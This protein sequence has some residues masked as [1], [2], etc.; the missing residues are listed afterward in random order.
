MELRLTTVWSWYVN[1]VASTKDRHQNRQSCGRERKPTSPGIASGRLGFSQTFLLDLLNLGK[2]CLILWGLE[3]DILPVL[4]SNA[5]CDTSA[6]GLEHV[7]GGVD[8]RWAHSTMPSKVV[9]DDLRV[10]SNFQFHQET[11][12]IPGTAQ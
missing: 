11:N 5:R 7:L 4:G 2:G 1:E 6:N 10:F 3:P 12:E 8:V 9:L